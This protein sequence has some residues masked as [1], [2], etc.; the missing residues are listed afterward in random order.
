MVIIKRNSQ[1]GVALVAALGVIVVVGIVAALVCKISVV[2]RQTASSYGRSVVSYNLAM[3]A[4]N[5]GYQ[6][7]MARHKDSAEQ[8]MNKFKSSG[9]DAIADVPTCSTD[10]KKCYWWLYDGDQP[11]N[12]N[13]WKNS[14]DW[15]VHVFDVSNTVAPQITGEAGSFFTPDASIYRIEKIGEAT[16]CDTA[17]N[18]W[19]WY[20]ITARG[21]DS[22]G[23]RTYL[24]EFV[25]IPVQCSSTLRLD[26]NP[27]E[28]TGTPTKR[29]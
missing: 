1:S 28:E 8:D 19:Q 26:K 17:N 15:D 23:S 13:G 25:K 20:R 3:S 7:L 6:T 5:A 4:L 29:F 27:D 11:Q 22:S 14:S 2:S 9:N 18:G 24:Q 12:F 21:L 16:S 10:Y